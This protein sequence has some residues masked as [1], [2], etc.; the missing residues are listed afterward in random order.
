MDT[1]RISPGSGTAMMPAAVKKVSDHAAS[2]LSGLTLAAVL[3]VGS[4]I[5]DLQTT[6]AV[7]DYRINALEV[8]GK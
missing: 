6:V 3:W 2:V 5:Q 1:P 7:H 8:E 4:S